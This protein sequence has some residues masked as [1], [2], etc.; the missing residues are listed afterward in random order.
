MHLYFSWNHYPT[1]TSSD[2]LDKK[3][4]GWKIKRKFIDKTMELISKTKLILLL[5]LI[6]FDN[7]LIWHRS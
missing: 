7:I 2:V 5:A 6:V 1:S 4:K 3:M